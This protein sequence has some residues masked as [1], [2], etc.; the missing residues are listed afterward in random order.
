MARARNI[1]CAGALLGIAAATALGA[2]PTGASAQDQALPLPAAAGGPFTLAATDGAIVTDQTYRGK[3]MLVYFGYTFCPDICP[4]S[5]SAMAGALDEL[6]SL[7]AKVQ[8]LFITIDPRR[9][10]PQILA[11]YVKSFDPRI[12]ALSGTPLQTAAAARAFGVLYERQDVE[13][14]DY[15]YNHTSYIY[16][17][18]KEGKFIEAFAGGADQ[19]KIARRLAQAIEGRSDA[20]TTN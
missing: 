7:A 9:D 2:A 19:A 16:L 4:T 12:V 15:V 5:L 11:E 10:T 3:W 13:D 8:P 14:G 1:I 18:D 20:T 6:G 17:M